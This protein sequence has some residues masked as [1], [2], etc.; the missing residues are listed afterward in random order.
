MIC[1]CNV[2]DLW[3]LSS[4]LQFSV[5]VSQLHLR[6]RLVYLET[7]EE[8]SKTGE[9]D[10]YQTAQVGCGDGRRKKSK[11]EKMAATT[12]FRLA[13]ETENNKFQGMSSLA[14]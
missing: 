3:L 7:D 5:A 1:Q 6:E 11:L 8:E 9:D 14:L 10:S 4:D 2:V 13:L 12:W